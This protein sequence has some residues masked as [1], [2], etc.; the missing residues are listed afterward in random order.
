LEFSTDPFSFS[1]IPDYRVLRTA[2]KR[3]MFRRLKAPSTPK[4]LNSYLGLIKHGN[5]FKIKRDI[6][7]LNRI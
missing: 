7:S 3:R 4:T 1:K 5:T 2:T 6:E